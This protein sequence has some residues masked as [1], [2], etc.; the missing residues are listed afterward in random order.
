MPPAIIAAAIGAG[1]ALIAGSQANDAAKSAS[2]AQAATAQQQLA[3]QQQQ[4]AQT[5]ANNA[6][7]LNAG[8]AAAAAAG[9]RL[10]LN[11][12]T[13]ATAGSP[14]YAA[15]LAANPD[16]QAWASADGNPANDAQQAAFQYQNYGQTEGRA[17]PTVATPGSPNPAVYGQQPTSVRPDA[18][19]APTYGPAPSY[20]SAAIGGTLGQAPSASDYLNGANF[21]TDPGYEF[22]RSEALRAVNAQAAAPNGSGFFSGARGKA[23]EDRATQLANQTYNDWYSRQQTAYGDA[24]SQYNTMAQTNLG[25]YN[26]DRAT[27]LT[28]YNND[29]NVL[30]SNYNTD[31]S[32]ALAQYNTNRTYD[33]TQ[34]QQATQNLFTLAGI[35]QTAA[36]AANTAGQNYATTSGNILQTNTNQQNTSAAAQAQN[37]GALATGLA[38]SAGNAIQSLWPAQKTEGQNVLAGGTQGI[39]F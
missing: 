19:A 9:D 22:T 25:Q 6:P 11:N 13:A 14:D 26:T 7:F 20:G 3:L 10:G 37:N 35:G 21:T 5:Q 36:G 29:R 33:T 2:D 27:G 31:S 17:L 28:Q 23:L 18:P 15:Y 24:A 8:S 34:Q 39:F 12:G 32:A 16:V 1:G 38:N 4:F 30:N